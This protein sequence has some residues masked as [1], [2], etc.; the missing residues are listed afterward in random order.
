MS[1][2]L[3]WTYIYGDLSRKLKEIDPFMLD[4]GE[5]AAAENRF[6]FEC[7][8]EA[9]NKVGGI[10]TVIRSKVAITSD[11]LGEQY[12]LSDELGE[13]YCLSDELGEQYCLFGPYN[14]QQVNQEVERME[15]SHPVFRDTL[16]SMRDQSV[17]VVFGRWLIE[18][19]PN[20]NLFDIG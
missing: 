13:Q 7:S 8:W 14:E 16:K 5:S 2:G 9:A 15:S 12:C 1:K 11:E 4:R 3:Y 10:Y 19:Y 18:G 17:K 6:V 20:I